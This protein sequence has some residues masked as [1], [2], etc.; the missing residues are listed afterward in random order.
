M[1]INITTNNNVTD[2]LQSLE[3]ETEIQYHESQFG[4]KPSVVHVIKMFE[5]NGDYESNADSMVLYY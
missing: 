1:K 2:I 4:K 3:L 5:D